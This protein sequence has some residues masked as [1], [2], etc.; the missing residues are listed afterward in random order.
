MKCCNN[1]LLQATDPGCNSNCAN[2]PDGK[3]V[4]ASANSYVNCTSA[5]LTPPV[6][7][8][9][10]GTVCCAG[11][12]VAPG[13]SA[14]ATGGSYTPPATPTYVTS[15]VV[16]TPT[17]VQKTTTVPPTYVQS[18]TSTPTPAVIYGSSNPCSGMADGA[19]VCTYCSGSAIVANT[20]NQPCPPGLVCCGNLGRCDVPGCPSNYTLSYGGGS[21][22][23]TCASIPDNNIV[24]KSATTYNI[25][26]SGGDSSY[27]DLPCPAG[28]VCCAN[29]NRCDVA[30]CGGTPSA[31]VPSPPPVPP[32]YP[33]PTGTCANQQDGAFVCTT[34]TSFNL[35]K[36]GAKAGADQLCATGSISFD[37]LQTCGPVGCNSTYG[38]Y[39]PPTNNY[40]PP[41]LYTG[42]GTCAN[43]PTGYMVCKSNTTLNYCANNAFAQAVDQSCP[44][45]LVCCEGLQRCD[46]AGCV[47]SPLPNAYSPCNK[48][49][50]NHIT[51]TSATTFNICANGLTGG[52]DQ[53][54]PAGTVCCANLNRCDVAGCAGVPSPVY[55]PSTPPS[56]IYP[57]P[58]GCQ[59]KQDN[60]L[61]CTSATTFNLCSNGVFPGFDQNPIPKGT[62]GQYNAGVANPGGSCANKPDNY[63]TCTAGNTFQL[64][65]AGKKSSKYDQICPTGLVCCETTQRCEFTCPVNYTPPPPPSCYGIADDHIVCTGPSSF[66]IC[67]NG[68]AAGATNQQC[69]NY[70]TVCCQN[71]NRCDWPGCSGN[72]TYK[73]VPP[74]YIPP[75]TTAVYNP[76]QPTVSPVPPVYGGSTPP[77]SCTGVA[78]DHIVC[79]SVSTYRF[80]KNGILVNS[81]DLTCP[82][83][84]MCCANLNMCGYIGC[85]ANNQLSYSPAP[86]PTYQ[87]C[88]GVKDGTMY[89]AS[90]TSINY[91]VNGSP[92]SAVNQPC[93]YGTVC[94]PNLGRCD[95]PGCSA[96]ASS[97]QTAYGVAHYAAKYGAGANSNGAT[98]Q[99]YG[100][101][102]PATKVNCTGQPNNHM[103]CASPTTLN[104]CF[105]GKPIK[106]YDQSCPYGLTCCEKTQRCEYTCPK[107]P[108]TTYTTVPVPTYPATKTC[109]NKKNNDIVC[110]SDTTFNICWNGAEAAAKDQSC[111]AGLK[112]CQG[113]NRCDWPSCN[114]TATAVPYVAPATC[115]TGKCVGK[116]DSTI[117]CTSQTTFNYCLNQLPVNALDQN[118]P[119]GT[120]CC[121]NLNR[122][123]WNCVTQAPPV[124]YNPTPT[125]YTPPPTPAYTP[126]CAGK[127]TGIVCL[128]QT[129]FNY[130]VNGALDTTDKIQSCPYGTIC[131]ADKGLCDFPDKCGSSLPVDPTYTP[132]AAP[133]CSGIKDNDIVCV[134]QAEYK[135]CLSGQYVVSAPLKCPYG[136]VCCANSNKCDYPGNC[137]Q[138]LPYHPPAMIAYS[139]ASTNLCA[140]LGDNTLVC[141]NPTAYTLCMRQVPAT[142]AMPCAPG[143]VCCQGRCVFANDPTCGTDYSNGLTYQGNPI[144]PCSVLG[145]AGNGYV[146][147]NG[148]WSSPIACSSDTT[149][150][151]CQNGIPI[152]DHRPCAKGTV[153]CGNAFAYVPPVV[154][155]PKYSTGNCTGVPNN[156]IICTSETTFNFCMNGAI[157]P[158]TLDQSCPVGLTCCE[159]LQ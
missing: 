130:C 156:N 52:V 113:L 43:K 23:P 128:S 85:P 16:P 5:L 63:L 119:A 149:Y 4:C 148:Y 151:F 11:A 72:S 53:C 39:V 40:V 145:V 34:A 87:N 123:D 134:S 67:K 110:K 77:V 106:A 2:V 56:N 27:V 154:T 95:Y 90:Q 103:L 22:A 152:S 112:C 19:L 64:C 76:G 137:Q 97:G 114:G 62:N 108:T 69:A 104:F 18:P 44:P 79:T 48:V 105:G 54:C 147:S 73:T 10:P 45:G 142:Q 21:K 146:T 88:V 92:L 101:V 111:P 35:C 7:P 50:D 42:V 75:A 96:S 32:T 133:T 38:T 66:N 122:C 138:T 135:Y 99:V 158:L 125:P 74:P 139:Y 124:V 107:D 132:V 83:G 121:E 141:V 33:F 6:M 12:C 159:S 49:P 71:L 58:Q 100:P 136:T 14:C 8:C 47:G 80:C 61:V 70:G 115:P 59:G 109:S 155:T 120:V 68:V 131:C 117:Y 13:S 51:C 15:I 1:K 65:S 153:C 94:C 143:T 82:S 17:Y 28:T 81:V 20:P 31:Y 126:T 36:N 157:L 93:P 25:C 84:T 140:G 57:N 102:L 9:A 118:C 60:Q 41:P 116:K 86:P 24:C 144:N 150:V 46:F 129:T 127:N 91:C 26:K 78:D 29:L 55:G 30:G 37:N 98:P 89:C 3:V